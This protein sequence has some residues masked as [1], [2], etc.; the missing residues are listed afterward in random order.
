[1]VCGL[2]MG[3]RMG[4]I[5][6]GQGSNPLGA[7]D[8]FLRVGF[9]TMVG[10]ALGSLIGTALGARMGH[11][12]GD[13]AGGFWLAL[14]ATLVGAVACVIVSMVATAIS[15]PALLLLPLAA[16]TGLELAMREE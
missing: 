8:G 12:F 15:L 5:I 2:F 14:G 10:V 3:H 9:V 16:A 11:Y 4:L 1:M 13:G 7:S 6:D